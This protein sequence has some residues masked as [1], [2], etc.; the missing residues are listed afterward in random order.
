M[1]IQSVLSLFLLFNVLFVGCGGGDSG[2]EPDNLGRTVSE[3]F[4]KSVLDSLA[5]IENAENIDAA[6]N[7]AQMAVENFENLVNDANAAQKPVVEEIAAK[8]G[9]LTNAKSLSEV[10]EQIAE[11]KAKAESLAQMAGETP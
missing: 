9:D 3:D 11:L 8:V 4:S 6:K 1:K 5:G 7:E 2:P 10:S